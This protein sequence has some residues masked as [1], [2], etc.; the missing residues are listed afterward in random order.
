MAERVE[1]WFNR[2]Y[3]RARRDVYLLRTPTDWQVLG[4]EGGSEGREVA[5]YFDD[6]AD[7]RTM[8]QAMLD[9]VEPQLSNW[10]LISQP[11]PR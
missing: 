10:A 5:H 11:S 3:G 7:A 1:H 4:R 2:R 9:S 8:V 6:E